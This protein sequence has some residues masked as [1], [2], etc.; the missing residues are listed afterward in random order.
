M[1]AQRTRKVR[2]LRIRTSR[3]CFLAIVASAAVALWPTMHAAFAQE[4]DA[5][6][7]TV[8][9]Y[10]MD[11]S[12]PPA[13][14]PQPPAPKPEPSANTANNSSSANNK[15]PGVGDGTPAP[16]ANAATSTAAPLAPVVP[17]LH[18]VD[19]NNP[20]AVQTANLLKMANNLKTEVDKTTADTLSVTVVREAGEIEQVARK[21][22]SR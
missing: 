3:L 16:V 6:Q 19:P 8:T 7:Q 12:Q 10:V 9:D 5:T 18:P 2:L 22:R 14:K 11:A 4:Q 21:M 1:R 17:P 15:A 13:K 20:L